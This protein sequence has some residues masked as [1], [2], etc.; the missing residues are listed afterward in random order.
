MKNLLILFA[1]VLCISSLA[2]AQTLQEKGYFNLTEF[3]FYT[4]NNTSMI[5]IT[6]DKYGG[7]TDGAYSFSLRNINGLFL[8]EK[9]SVGA[10]I[11]LENYTHT[12]NSANNNMFL[13]FLD[14]RYYFKNQENTFFA[15]GDA[16]GS[17]KIADHFSKGPMYNLGIGYKFKI[18]PKMGMTGSLGYNDQV[19]KHDEDA[20][21]KDR[22]YGFAL[23]VGLLL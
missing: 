3:G 2:N 18:S 10:G 5:E 17:I 4:G 6:P 22:Y 8:T 14:A 12:E 9:I 13:L 23:R 16:G 20:V 11:G 19:I 21:I 7:G 15:Y 1:C